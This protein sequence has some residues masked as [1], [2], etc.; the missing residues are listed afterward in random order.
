MPSVDIHITYDFICPWCWIG[1][2]H[3]LAALAQVPEIPVTVH[4]RAYELNPSMPREG[5]DRRAYRSAKFGSWA[6]SQAM[7]ADV[8]LAGQRAGIEF[9]YDRVLITPNTRL[10]HRL[11]VFADNQ[12]DPAKTQALF[13][14]VFHAYFSE[15]QDIGKADLLAALAVQ[16]GF[17][18][19]AARDYLAT[20]AGEREVIAAQLQAQ[21]DGVHSV[22]SV[23]IGNTLISGAQPAT[24]LVQAL[25]KAATQGAAESTV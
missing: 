18:A 14:G 12:G 11:M 16:A 2:Q 1:H 15:G 19:Q 17:D 3:L 10:A 24:A 6:R 21:A 5:S 13:E 22:P 20:S 23:L 25:Q 9:H 4:Y 8:T 7:D